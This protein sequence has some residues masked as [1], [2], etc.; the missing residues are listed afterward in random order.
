MLT[1]VPSAPLSGTRPTLSVVTPAFNEAANLPLLYARLQEVMQAQGVEWEWVI[2]DD[3]SQ[4][5]TFQ[6]IQELARKHGRV[7]GIRFSR[8]FGSHAA[9]TCGLHAA[10]GQC[11]VIM[12]ADLQD[13]PETLPELLRKWRDG[14]QVVWA[15]RAQRLGESTGTLTFSRLYYFLVRHLVGM[16]EMPS[17]GAD[18]FLVDRRVLEAFRALGERN[19]SIFML[20]TWM[21]FRQET[22]SYVKQARVHGSSGWSLEK[23]FKLVLDSV[24][25]FTYVPIRAISYLGVVVATLGFIYALFVIYNYFSGTPNQ[26]WSSL[27]VVVLVMGGVQLLMMGLLGEYLWRVLEETKGRPL[28]LVESTTDSSST[29]GARDERSTG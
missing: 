8:N 17:S 28:Y 19:V 15:V 16:K 21:G 12:A 29:D 6:V 1:V 5:G 10:S 11:A 18:F 24:T 9:I 20:I 27:M 13:P 2:V 25:S 22:I 4:D 26:G 3:H 14:A 23:R 7:R